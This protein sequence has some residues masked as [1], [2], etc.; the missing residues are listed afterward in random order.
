M[1]RNRAMLGVWSPHA[2][3]RVW[4][5]V[6]VGAAL[7]GL[8]GG[9][10]KA[11]DNGLIAVSGRITL[12][13]QPLTRALICFCSKSNELSAITNADGSYQLKPGAPPGDYLVY[14]NKP[15]GG[16]QAVEPMSRGRVVAAPRAP[17]LPEQLVPAHYGDPQQTKLHFTVKPS[18]TS[19][20]DF[21]LTSQ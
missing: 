5:V 6:L 4:M 9:C 3:F 20:A 12:D 18:G 1:Y 7:V 16:P 19:R 10:R 11:T 2:V 8:D 21:E 14:I 17:V 13:G 15:K